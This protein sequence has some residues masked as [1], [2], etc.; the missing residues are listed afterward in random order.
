MF[1]INVSGG[2]VSIECYKGESSR[3]VDP[4]LPNFCRK[5]YSKL[6]NYLLSQRYEKFVFLL[7][8]AN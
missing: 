6:Q 5:P 7:D 4:Y 2:W 1:E 8:K 3:E